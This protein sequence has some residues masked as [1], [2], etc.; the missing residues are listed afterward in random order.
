MEEV[1][2]AVLQR[3]ERLILKRRA[4]VTHPDS[5]PEIE[6]V[7]AWLESIWGNLV[8][9]SIKHGHEGIH[10][11]LGWSHQ[12]GQY[13]FW[14]NDNGEGIPPEKVANLF[15][16]FNLLHRLDSRRGLGLSVVRRL[17]ELQGGECGYTPQSFGGSS[18]YFTLPAQADRLADSQE[19]GRY[20]SS[21]RLRETKA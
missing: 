15:Q 1:I 17:V 11:E 16:P 20:K 14:V 5:W 7:G 19:T 6:G 12:D 8:E 3:Y 18:F 10:V 4:R 13:R 2:W 9:N 21:Q